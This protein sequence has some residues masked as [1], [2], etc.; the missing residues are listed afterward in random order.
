LTSSS[1]WFMAT[2]PSIS[3]TRTSGRPAVR[4]IRGV[5]LTNSRAAMECTALTNLSYIE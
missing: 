2:G 1:G 5:S 3:A 4:S